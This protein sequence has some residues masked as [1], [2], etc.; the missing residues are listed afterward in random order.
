MDEEIEL[1][2]SEAC[3][4]QRRA[5]RTAGRGRAYLESMLRRQAEGLLDHN[6]TF[7]AF[8]VEGQQE[9]YEDAKDA[10]AWT[11]V[12]HRLLEDRIESG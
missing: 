6:V 12:Y 4:A 9:G 3:R 2:A 1:V 8:A 10:R 7:A 11:S 5:A